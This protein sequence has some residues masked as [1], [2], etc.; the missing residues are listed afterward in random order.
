MGAKVRIG[1]PD[2]GREVARYIKWTDTE[3]IVTPAPVYVGRRS[4]EC[5]RT[6]LEKADGILTDNFITANNTTH[7]VQILEDECPNPFAGTNQDRDCQINSWQPIAGYGDEFK[8]IDVYQYQDDQKYFNNLCVLDMIEIQGGPFGEPQLRGQVEFWSDESGWEPASYYDEWTNTKIIAQPPDAHKGQ[9]SADCP[10]RDPGGQ[11]S[12]KVSLFKGAFRVW[13]GHDGS[14]LYYDLLNDEIKVKVEDG[15]YQ[16]AQTVNSEIFE[17]IAEQT[18][19][20]QEATLADV[21]FEEAVKAFEVA[22]YNTAALKF[23]KAV[24]LAPED[25][26]L[27]FAYGQALLASEQY[28]K[29]AEVLRGA[30]AKVSP[31]KEGV[32]FPRGLYPDG[33]GIKGIKGKELKVSEEL[34]VSGTFWEISARN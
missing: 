24:E 27:P 8:P 2:D 3:I 28:S 5:P 23:A 14:Y 19:E 4:P 16:P 29:A 21:Y 32:F 10:R 13:N 22:Q 34:K 7:I 31:E 9:L 25:M 20:P 17:N 11:L 6:S 1:P 33:A 30:L 18:P 15:D 12:N 26:I